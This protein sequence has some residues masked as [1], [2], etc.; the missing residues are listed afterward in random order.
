[1]ILSDYLNW[2]DKVTFIISKY[3]INQTDKQSFIEFHRFALSNRCYEDVK[4]ETNKILIEEYK[5]SD[6]DIKSIEE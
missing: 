3:P 4:K 6:K 1:M 2:W 5:L